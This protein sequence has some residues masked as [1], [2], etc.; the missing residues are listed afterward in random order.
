M[1]ISYGE[2]A[3]W[4]GVIEMHLIYTPVTVRDK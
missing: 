1:G 2:E 4:M 3:W